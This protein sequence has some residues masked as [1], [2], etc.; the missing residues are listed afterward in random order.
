MGRAIEY[1]PYIVYAVTEMSRRGL[2]ADRAQFDLKEV[3]LIDERDEKTS[4]F[5]GESQRIITPPGA[6]RSLGEL[7]RQRLESPF[8]E[9]NVRETP[10]DLTQETTAT[11]KHLKLRFLTPTRIRVDGDLQV[12]MSFSLLVRNLLRRVSLLT[13]VHGSTPMQ[14]DFRGL[15]EQAESVRTIESNLNW[16]DWERYS[17]RQ[18]KKMKLGGFMGDVVYEGDLLSQ[19]LP[20]VAAGELL[21]AGA[22]TAFGLGRLENVN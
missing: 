3:H 6:T 10:N 5:S 9:E 16:C 4:V 12:S 15:I 11:A 8:P 18:Q 20:L 14:V 17:N 22:G 13:A 21:N 2:G 19:F 1:L 7:I